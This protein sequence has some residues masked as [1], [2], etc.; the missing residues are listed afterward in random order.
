MKAMAALALGGFATLLLE[1]R[2]E[3]RVVLG[4]TWRAYIPL[5]CAG[6]VLLVG[7]VA[8]VRWTRATRS[9]LAGAFAVAIVVGMLGMVFHGGPRA[10]KQVL[11]AWA[12]RP[13]QS[14]GP[15]PGSEPPP[16]APLSF[17]GLGALGFAACRQRKAV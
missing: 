8:L 17:C 9:A 15:A 10:V 4:E 12:L 16:L 6:A 3:H 2:H 14:G 11:H 1:I 7:T 13:G 5:A